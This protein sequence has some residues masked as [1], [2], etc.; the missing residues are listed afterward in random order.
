MI[1]RK[2]NDLLGFMLVLG[3]GEEVVFQVIKVVNIDS[4]MG[5]VVV[6]CVNSFFSIMFLGDE[7]VVYYV[8]EMF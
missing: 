7:L 4:E 2:F 1:V 6:V 8:F 5:C 3:Y